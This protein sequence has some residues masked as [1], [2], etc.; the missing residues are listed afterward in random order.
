MNTAELFESFRVACR[1]PSDLERWALA[2]VPEMLRRIE[3]LQAEKAMRESQWEAAKSSAESKW[4][5]EAFEWLHQ[6]QIEAARQAYRITDCE[7][8]D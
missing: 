1:K 5:R 6:Y 4:Q 2:H 8:E 3:E 7:G